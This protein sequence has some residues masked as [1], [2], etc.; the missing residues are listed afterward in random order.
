MSKLDE[1]IQELCPN[2]VKYRTLGEV[3]NIT[4]GFPFSA[5]DFKVQGAY[6]IVRI[7]DI[8]D[9]VVNVS[10]K[11]VDDL[12]LKIKQ[13]QI[14]HGAEILV[15][16]SGSTGKTGY[17]S[18]PNLLVN[19]RI[20]IIRNNELVLNGFLKHCLVNSNFS[21]Y[22]FKNGTGPQ[23]NLSKGDRKSVV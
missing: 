13:E 8:F 16:L 10:D 14:L 21:D 19:Q 2:G 4:D 20:A 22:C 11:Y 3:S 12:P 6:S 15:G 23:N 5:K 9:G 18:V 17:N 1:L 7:S